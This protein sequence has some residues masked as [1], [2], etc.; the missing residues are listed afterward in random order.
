M[1]EDWD[2]GEADFFHISVLWEDGVDTGGRTG[3]P[4]YRPQL[5]TGLS[6][7]CTVDLLVYPNIL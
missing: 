3:G 5:R 4:L 2:S 7:V 6:R 1:A